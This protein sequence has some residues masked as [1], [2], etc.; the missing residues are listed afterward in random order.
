[1]SVELEQVRTYHVNEI[2]YSIQGEGVRAG[3]PSVFLR[4]QGCN[5]QCNIKPGPQSPGGFAC[6]TEFASGKAM[7]Q[8]QIVEGIREACGGKWCEWIVLT[9]GEPALQLDYYLIDRLRAEGYKMAI[10]TNGTR[11]IDSFR[12]DWVCVSPKVAEHAIAQLNADEVKYVRAYG[13]EIPKTRVKAAHKLISPAFHGGQLD[14]KTL[15][16]CVQLVK[17]NPEWRLSLQLHQLVG[18]R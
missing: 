14:R 18:V 3:C 8:D 4:F 15:D 17:D 13:Q 9:G 2:F 11:C 16:W 6:D 10:E 7:D 12:L 1:M 5:L